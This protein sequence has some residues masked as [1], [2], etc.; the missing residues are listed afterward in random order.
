MQSRRLGLVG[1]ANRCSIRSLLSTIAQTSQK[2]KSMKSLSTVSCISV[3]LAMTGTA[4][5]IA[6]PDN[7][8]CNL[9]FG[10]CL[11]ITNNN[12]GASATAIFGSSTNGGGVSGNS[13]GGNGVTGHSSTADG[14]FGQSFSGTG[15][16]G[17]VHGLSNG[18]SGNGVFGQN[19][20]SAGIGV[21]GKT[22]AGGIAIYGDNTDGSVGWAGFFNGDISAR[23]YTTS[24]DAR[25]KKDVKDLPL[26]IEALLQLRP[27][28][29]KWIKEGS[30]DGNQ[31]GL[32][33]QEVQ[34]IVPDIV[35]ADAATGMLSVNYTAL[36]P[37]MIKVGQEQQ[38]LIQ[39]QEVRNERSSASAR[40]FVPRSSREVRSARL[41]LLVGCP[42]LL[43][44]LFAS[45]G[46]RPARTSGQSAK[47]R[48]EPRVAGGR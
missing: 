15:A 33:A 18:S 23:S 32:I 10:Q 27:V 6:L 4:G 12:T 9:N 45:A 5:A 19:A 2:E 8:S 26:G 48:T 30:G 28:T 39:R 20:S 43:W 14:V 37:I 22:N 24:S 46:N 40:A 17:G 35:R 31:F 36:I 7:S 11:G 42:S 13:T 47:A 3:F 25:L 1:A 41:W 34:K 21:L 44:S 38:R 16:Q 29:Y